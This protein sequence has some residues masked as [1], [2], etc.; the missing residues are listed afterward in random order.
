MIRGLEYLSYGASPESWSCS[1]WRR[2]W[3]EENLESFP[4]PEGGYKRD[5]EG[6]FTREGGDRTRGNNFKPKENSLNWI[7]G[8]N[9]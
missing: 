4:V 1:A 2:L 3:G 7:L 8:R 5:K 9:S 6:H